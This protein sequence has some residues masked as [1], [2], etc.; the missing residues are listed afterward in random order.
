MRHFRCICLNCF[1]ILRCFC[2]GQHKIEKMPFENFRI[3]AQEGNMKI[4][5]FENTLNSFSSSLLWSILVSKLPQFFSK[6]YWFGQ[7]II[8]FQ[9]VDTLRLLKIYI[10]FCLP[11]GAKYP[12]FLGSSS[13]TMLEVEENFMQS[14]S[15]FL[16]LFWW[17]KKKLLRALLT[18][19]FI[20]LLLNFFDLHS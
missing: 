3:I 2:W 12:F 6:S 9:K 18:C 11:A 16:L 20:H 19:T 4:S 14:L 5:E 17:Q 7:L 13:W 1:N 8:L 10:M 15:A